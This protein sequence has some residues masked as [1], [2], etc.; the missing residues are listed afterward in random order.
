MPKKQR[1]DDERPNAHRRKYPQC[2]ADSQGTGERCQ[3]NVI[4]G[5][6]YCKAHSGGAAKQTGL[7]SPNFKHG[8]HSGGSPQQRTMAGKTRW[9][10]SVPARLITH[11]ERSLADQDVLSLKPELALIDAM[12]G[13]Q[14]EGL[15]QDGYPA[16]FERLA[17]LV[18]DLNDAEESNNSAAMA[19]A[20]V[21]IKKAVL[22]GNKQA[23]KRT[24]IREL[25]RERKSLA[26]SERKHQIEQGLMVSTLDMATVFGIIIGIIQR[27]V[28]NEKEQ[29]TIFGEMERL[30]LGRFMPA[31]G[32]VNAPV[33]LEDGTVL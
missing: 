2:Q 10:A 20:I 13:E 16:L 1:P 9:A 14:I 23:E 17:G 8:K 33:V 3:K 7:A 25:I 29:A 15:D 24:E 11:F 19:K 5:S 4:Q 26:E 31:Y 12:L 30:V 32:A 27:N 21:A 22:H 6:L 28:S 18:K